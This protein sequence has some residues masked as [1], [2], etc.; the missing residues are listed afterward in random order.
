MWSFSNLVEASGAG[1]INELHRGDARPDN[2]TRRG[3]GRSLN[4]GN[5]TVLT[6]TKKGEPNKCLQ[7][8][9]ETKR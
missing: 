3:R 7:S 5:Y 2:K 8:S 9:T 1:A 6:A 4:F